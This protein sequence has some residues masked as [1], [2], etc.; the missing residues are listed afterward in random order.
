M[1]FII[2]GGLIAILFAFGM[3]FANKERREQE[4]E[5]KEAHMA[6]SW[7]GEERRRR[8]RRSGID[9]RHARVNA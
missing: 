7:D 9:R 2:T 4:Q 5:D 3:Y 8:D 1:A 6:I